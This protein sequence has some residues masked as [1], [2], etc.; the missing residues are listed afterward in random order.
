MAVPGPGTES[1]WKLQPVSQWC[2]MESLTQCARP[3]IE[4]TPLQLPELPILSF[5]FFFFFFCLFRA[6]PE[7]YRSSQARG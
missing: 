1:K 7:V 6:T 4:P 5:L 3:G 2:N